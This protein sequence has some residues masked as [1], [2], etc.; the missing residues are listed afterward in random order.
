MKQQTADSR[1][2]YY[3]LLF[4]NILTLI[5]LTIISLHYKVPQ[6]VL[7]KLGII[8]NKSIVYSNYEIL[9]KLFPVYDKTYKYKIVMLGDSITAGVAWNEL[10]GINYI[11]NRGIGSDTTDGF[12]KQLENIYELE[13]ES[14]FI[15][16]GINDI[17]AGITVDEILKNFEIIVDNLHQR[18]VKVII[19]STLYVSK[20]RPKWKKINNIVDELNN[21]LKQICI[22][23]E[24]V[25]VDVNTALSNDNALNEEYTYDGVHL[26]GNG[27]TKWKELI[28]PI[29]KNGM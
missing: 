2:Y 10:L 19:Q 6:K 7:I 13:P 26:F 8:E 23:N 25:Y 27:Y 20:N 24:L 12:V 29:I 15:M 17:H 4:T 14:C 3:V 28:L 1:R 16:G 9:N 11:A 5:F 18:G 21:G 22:K